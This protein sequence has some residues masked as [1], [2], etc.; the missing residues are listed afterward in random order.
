MTDQYAL[1][2]IAA[3][4]RRFAE[5]EA[6]GHSPLYEA[7]ALGVAED[8]VVLAFLAGLPADKQQPNLLFAALRHVCGTPD[9][10]PAF[11][12]G[13]ERHAVAISAVM[14]ARRTQTNEPARC[15]VLLPVLATL[16]G[17]LSLIEVGASAGLCLLPDRYAY[18]Y[19]DDPLRG[20][21]SAA[22]APVFPCLLS[23]EITPP[24]RLP[25]I[26]WRAGLDLNPIDA[27]DTDQSAWL[28]TLVWPDQPAR[29][30]RLQQAL[31]VART[32]PPRIVQGDLLHDLPKLAA[33]APAG[34]ALV[35]FHTA[36][37]AYVA[38]QALRDAFAQTVRDSGA[39]WI[40]NEVP[41]ATPDIA[42]RA[43]TRRPGGAFL[44]SVNGDPVAWTDP[45]GAWMQAA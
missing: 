22:D 34:T 4:Y 14:L 7:V 39:T 25:D 18:D 24:Q 1:Q 17:P 8:P 28:E 32:N 29:L 42:A 20:T 35:V 41:G 21:A 2:R 15:A 26:A 27:R 12:S 23:N 11:R 45:H 6:R 13:L 31:A 33:A 44:L 10:W 43:R 37:L 30:Q 36:V 38:D 40:C 3:R 5:Q 19:G 16:P 9:G